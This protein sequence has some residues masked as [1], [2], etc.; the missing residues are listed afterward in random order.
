MH[1]QTVRRV[2][3]AGGGTAGWIAAAALGRLLGPL[4]DITL[5]ESDEIG[6]VGVGESTIPT[7]RT[8][9]HL[10]GIDEREFMRATQVDL[11][12]RHRVRGLG[13]RSATATSTPSAR[14][15]RSTWMADFHHFWLQARERGPGRRP[16]RLLPRA[17]GGRGGQFRHVGRSQ[18]QLRLSS[19]RRALYARFLRRFAKTPASKR[20][21][22]K[23]AEVEQHAETGFIEALVL[24]SGDARRGR[25]V[26]RLHRLSRPADRA[27][28]RGRI[29]R[30][31]AHWLPT[32]SGARRADRI[33]RPRHPL[34]PRDRAR[35]GLAV[36][37]PA[38]APR[39]QRP[40]LFAATIMSDDEARAPAARA[41]RGRGADRAAADPLH[42]P[43]SAARSGTRTASRFGLS[44]GF[45]EPLESTSIHLIMIGV[46]AADAALPVR[47][48]HR[49]R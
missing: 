34:H 37:H 36:A 21:E 33:G 16:R 24:E 13:A 30:T 23:I 10:L 15:A 11:Q 43:A 44:S 9:H 22:G 14:S 26:H 45:V 25:P 49:R 39:R 20:I 42:A 40:R 19:R 35:C 7:A 28:A 8:F 27:D 38:A 12:A 32:D 3:I 47:R 6:T 48:H 1:G 2:V 18:H 29:S 46:D 17:A 31:G 4:L 41:D 5:V